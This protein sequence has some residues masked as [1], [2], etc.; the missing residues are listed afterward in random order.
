[1]NAIAR[2]HDWPGYLRSPRPSLSLTE[3]ELDA[4]TGVYRI[5]YGLAAE[6]I[7]IRREGVALYT[8][9]DLVPDA[10]ALLA[11]RTEL[12]SPQAPYDVRL[13]FGGDGRVQMLR[14]FEE[15]LLILE[16]VRDDRCPDWR[17]ASHGG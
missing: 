17:P 10:P 1:L 7:G 14:V 9:M 6:R 12:Y 11:S 8:M 13:E 5:T 3:T 15:D 4:Y 16:A 2:V